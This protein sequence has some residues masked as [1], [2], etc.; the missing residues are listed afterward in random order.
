MLL[1]NNLPEQYSEEIAKIANIWADNMKTYEEK[2]DSTD[3]IH[4]Y[5][6]RTNIGAL[7]S[8]VW[9][10]GG[11]AI[12]EYGSAKGVEE[13]Y[14]GRN[15]LY[16]HIGDIKAVAEAKLVW[17]KVGYAPGYEIMLTD[18]V[19]DAIDPIDKAVENAESDI[20]K[21]I[22]EHDKFVAV[23][24]NTYHKSEYKENVKALTIIEDH[25]RKIDS[26]LVIRYSTR[27]DLKSSKNNI[28]NHAYLIIAKR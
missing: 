18:L 27:K 4:W 9:M 23:F 7:A 10:G 21:V 3:S 19:R 15:D 11:V 25:L 2:Y 20:S 22:T 16:F 24:V 13:K 26:A 12:E 17:A 8:A 6:E 28:C 5:L 1:C 14:S